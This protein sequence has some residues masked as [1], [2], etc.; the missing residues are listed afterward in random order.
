MCMCSCDCVLAYFPS[1]HMF[2]C[3]SLCAHL[4]VRTSLTVCVCV[5]FEELQCHGAG[6]D[7]APG[8]ITIRCDRD[9]WKMNPLMWCLGNTDRKPSLQTL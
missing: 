7:R 6:V 3:V 9:E 5:L 1:L 4:W 2:W 8:Y